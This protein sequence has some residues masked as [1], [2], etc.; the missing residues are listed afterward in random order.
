[1]TNEERDLIEKFVARVG[2][3]ASGGFTPA[4]RRPSPAWRRSTRRRTASSPQQFQSHPEARYRITQMAVVQEAALAEAA[5]RIQRMQAELEQ[6]RQQAQP[7]QPAAGS[8]V[9]S[10]GGLFGGGQP[11]QPQLAASR[12]GT[13]V[14]RSSKTRS[15]NMPSRAMPRRADAAP[16]QRAARHVPA[17]RRSGFLGSALSTAAGVAGGVVAGNVLMDMF[18]G[19]GGMAGS[20]AA[21]GAASAAACPC[22]RDH[23]HQQLRRC[24]PEGGARG[25]DNATQAGSDPAGTT[26]ARATGRRRWD[27]N[28]GGGGGGFDDNSL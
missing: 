20:A 4:C 27:D 11:R 12:R 13:R 16:A 18:S 6:A 21:W 26:A 2:G 28:G 9:A 14:R 7:A 24:R 5:N 17:L 19:H 25:W 1:M 22:R 15:R 8:R 3:A 23:H 10:S